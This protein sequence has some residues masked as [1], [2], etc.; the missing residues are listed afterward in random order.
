MLVKISSMAQVSATARGCTLMPCLLGGLASYFSSSVFL[1]SGLGLHLSHAQSLHWLQTR[2]AVESPALE[3]VKSHVDVVLQQQLSVPA[4]AGHWN[5]WTRF[6][7]RQ[8]ETSQL[9]LSLH[10]SA[11][12]F[13]GSYSSALI[14][15]STDASLLPGFPILPSCWLGNVRTVGTSPLSSTVQPP[16]DRWREG[17]KLQFGPYVP[18]EAL[19]ERCGTTFAT[20]SCCA[21]REE[22]VCLVQEG[23]MSHQQ[24]KQHG[25]ILHPRNSINSESHLP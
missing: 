3:T 16:R 21:Q 19:G 1:C 18:K 24:G 2:E 5:R 15:P 22:E 7:H 4:W 20:H 12:P 9:L 11:G 14:L 13:F 25:C 8:L 10:H 6:H 23:A 17:C